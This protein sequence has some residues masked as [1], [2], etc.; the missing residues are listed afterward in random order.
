MIEGMLLAEIESLFEGQSEAVFV[1][2]EIIF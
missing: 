1:L 2:C